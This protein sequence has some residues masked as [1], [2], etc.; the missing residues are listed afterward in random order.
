MQISILESKHSNLFKI[1]HSSVWM[2]GALT[3][4]I[5]GVNF[6]SN[7]HPKL[8][9]SIHLC[10]NNQLRV[11][12]KYSRLTEHYF[13]FKLNSYFFSFYFDL[14]F[15]LN[16]VVEGLEKRDTGGGVDTLMMETHLSSL[17][18]NISCLQWTGWIAG[19]NLIIR[20]STLW[21]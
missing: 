19:E 4:K 12:M 18:K 21:Q 2:T 8:D 13:L 7:E 17:R 3:S 15:H 10:L 6:V 14:F 11:I 20:L 16:F 9:N 1:S 5:C